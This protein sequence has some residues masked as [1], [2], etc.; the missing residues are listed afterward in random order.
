MKL[1]I[2]LLGFLSFASVSFLFAQTDSSTQ[3]SGALQEL[4][5]SGIKTNPKLEVTQVTLK[6]AALQQKYFGADVPSLLNS[7]PS[8]N[9][10]SDN[11]T[12]FGYSYLRIRGMDQSRV[13]HSINGIP[14]NDPE[15]QSVYFNN[16]ADL[17]SGLEQIQVQRGVGISGNGG[18]SYAGSIQM[19][20]QSVQQNQAFELNM[21]IGSF[22]SRRLGFAY[23]SGI[24]KNFGV[25]AR[26]GQV[27]TNGYRLSSGMQANNYQ[28]SMAYFIP[29]GVIAL[30]VFGGFASSNLAYVGIEKDSLNT[31][32]TYNPLNRGEKDGFNQHFFQL[33][34]SQQ[35]NHAFSFNSSAYLVL[36]KATD[37]QYFFPKSEYTPLAYFNLPNW[38]NG[39]DS[40]RT[41]DVMTSYRLNQVFTGVFSNISYTHHKLQAVVG[42]HANTFSADHFM[43]VQNGDSLPP[44]IQGNEHQV[45]LNTG[46]KNE[47]SV[48]SKLAYSFNS[49]LA[50]FIDFSLRNTSF[51]YS[52]KQMAYRADHLNTVEPMNWLFFNPRFGLNYK[53]NSYTKLYSN[54]GMSQREPTR[55]DYFN[56]D[57]ANSSIK[58][59][60][61]K[62]EK[63]YNAELGLLVNHSKIST[64]INGFYMYFVDQIASTGTLNSYGMPINSNVG[65]SFRAGLE[66]DFAWKVLPN[67]TLSHTA[68]FSQNKIEKITLKYSNSLN[69]SDTFIN[70]ENTT[71]AFSPSLI[72]NQGIKYAPIKGIELECMGRYVSEQYLDNSNNAALLLPSFALLDFKTQLTPDFKFTQV[73]MQ[74]TFRVQNVLDVQYSPM[75]S[76]RPYTNTIDPSTHKIG[77]VPLFFPAAGRNFFVN[78]VFRF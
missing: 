15:S 38:Y 24:H 47:W 78:A 68:A 70:F 55:F 16:I 4:I 22:G 33:Q 6:R 56:D 29:E 45:Y 62:A 30:N 35:I 49:N 46:T 21:G 58:Q 32:R 8:V 65:K 2:C 28:L 23:Q 37:F 52:A 7:T 39:T 63:V 61:I 3:K 60:A 31:N 64:A 71:A 25:Y 34:F 9:S 42:I 59:S 72:L 17:T 27:A 5:I 11:G 69:Y 26:I 57:L 36:G 51:T 1:K 67:L 50:G 20:T 76:I 40:V 48:Y 12:G 66:I 44:S 43:V 14:L 54:F 41:S 19:L 10:Y 77:T 13:N 74:F 73:K 18:S 53:I 75:G